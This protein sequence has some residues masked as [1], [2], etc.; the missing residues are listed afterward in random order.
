MA[1]GTYSNNITLKVGGAIS[2]STTST[3][4]LYTCSSTGYA[5]VNLY[6]SAGVTVTIGG[7][8]VF[9]NGTPGSSLL[10]GQGFV[11]GPSQAVAV[12]VNGSGATVA[13]SGVEFVNSP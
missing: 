4:T 2:G 6:A 9:A 10:P 5:M 13:I 11:V 12:T 1:G 8:I 3:A 7:Q